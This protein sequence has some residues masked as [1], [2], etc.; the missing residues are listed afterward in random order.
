MKQKSKNASV[1]FAVLKEEIADM[2]TQLQEFARKTL[3]EGLA[4][5]SPEQQMIFKR[6]YVQRKR[7]DGA[8]AE[9]ALA[10]AAEI[11]DVVDKMPEER[12]DW[13]MQQVESTLIKNQKGEDALWAA[14]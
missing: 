11:N 2:N 3:K 5:C 6:M 10:K 12:L 13:A 4:Q 7:W 14:A 8:E 9:I 1:R